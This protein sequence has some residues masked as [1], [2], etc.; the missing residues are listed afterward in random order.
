MGFDMFRD[1]CSRQHDPIQYPPAP[2]PPGDGSVTELG[3]VKEFSVFFLTMP[4]VPF[5]FP[6]YPDGQM[7][8][9]GDINLI[10]LN[11]KQE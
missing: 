8:I 3:E 7:S 1:E 4:Y 2:L 11:I 10:L 6:L 9:F 5:I